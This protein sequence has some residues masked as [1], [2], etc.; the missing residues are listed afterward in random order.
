MTIEGELVTKYFCSEHLCLKYLDVP[1]FQAYL[2]SFV[3]PWHPCSDKDQRPVRTTLLPIWWPAIASV[4]QFVLII[5]QNSMR[6]YTDRYRASKC[7][8]KPQTI[9]NSTE[10]SQSTKLYCTHQFLKFSHSVVLIMDVFQTQAC[11]FV[12]CMILC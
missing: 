10:H 3:T 9:S 12:F 7:N 4:L 6:D 8:N 1:S 11:G 5:D 2:D